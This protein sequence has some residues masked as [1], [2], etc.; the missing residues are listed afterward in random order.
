MPA[1]PKIARTVAEAQV[2]D[3]LWRFDAERPYYDENGKYLGRGVWD[4][5]TVLAVHR[6]Y[7]TAGDTKHPHSASRFARAD[8][9]A[10]TRQGYTPS[11]CVCGSADRRDR[12]W[13]DARL[14]IAKKVEQVADRDVLETIAFALGME[15]PPD[16]SIAP[17]PEGPDHA[18]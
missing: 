2:Y 15:P 5:V 1:D 11:E 12:W 18:P 3:L 14:Q 10:H 13:H 6:I 9:G 4:I 17:T 7:L 16:F 8:G